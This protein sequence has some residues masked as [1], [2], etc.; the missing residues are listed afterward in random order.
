MELTSEFTAVGPDFVTQG[1]KPPRDSY[2]VGAMFSLFAQQSWTL[3]ASY[4]FNFKD[5]YTANAGFVRARYEW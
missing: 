3:T 5:D 4:D 2:N 1:F